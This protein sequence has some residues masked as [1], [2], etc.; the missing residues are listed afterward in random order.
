MIGKRTYV[1]IAAALIVS[2][3]SHAVNPSWSYDNNVGLA[4]VTAEHACLSITHSSLTPNTRA[5]IIDTQRQREM[6]AVVVAGRQACAGDSAGMT[7][8]E[9]RLDA[10]DVQ[11]PFVGIAVIGDGVSLV[12]RGT[13]LAGDLDR[14]GRDEFFRTCTSAE[15]VHATVWSG[16]AL[17]GTRRWHRY[18]ALG[19][20]VEANCTPAEVSP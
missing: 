13:E 12:K 1:L 7:G 16:A 5:R 9:M 20:D 3:R 2:C 11:R 14:D 10:A 19:Y 4:V 18:H 15:G 8:Y 17:S 6:P